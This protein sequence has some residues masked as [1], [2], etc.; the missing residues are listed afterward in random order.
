MKNSC[1][2]SDCHSPALARGWCKKHYDRWRRHGDP[3]I[4]FLALSPRGEPMRWLIAH[5]AHDSDECL[6][7]PFARFPDGRAHMHAG[8]PARIMCELAHGAPPTPKHEAAHSCGKAHEGCVNQKHLRWA[9]SKENTADKFL[10]GTVPCGSALPQAKLTEGDVR[11]I[12]QSAGEV[13]PKSLAA[14]FGV[15]VA[16]ISM[17]IN[18]KTWRH[19]S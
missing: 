19:V 10:H 3:N 15:G 16:S 13:S 2:I 6:I 9:T 1:A 4:C 11:A 5:A 8:K 14:R 18:L 17:I 7:W 12:R